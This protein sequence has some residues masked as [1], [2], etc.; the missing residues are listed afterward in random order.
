MGSTPALFTDSSPI[1]SMTSIPVKKQSARK[2]LCLFTNILY[3]NNKTAT[4]QVGDAIQKRKSIKYAT[5]PWELKKKLKGN[6]KIN[7]QINMSLYN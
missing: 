7:G 3:V 6:S 4:R 5:T 1:Y 2:S